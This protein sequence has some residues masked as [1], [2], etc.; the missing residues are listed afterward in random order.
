MC[1]YINKHLSNY[2]TKL[3]NTFRPIPD[4]ISLAPYPGY[5]AITSLLKVLAK[6]CPVQWMTLTYAHFVNREMWFIGCP[7]HTAIPV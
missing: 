2:L 3:L 6:L 5:E 4:L 7:W 1:V